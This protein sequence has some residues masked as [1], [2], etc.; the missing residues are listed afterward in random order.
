VDVAAASADLI[1]GCL[2][3]RV[4]EHVLHVLLLLLLMLTLRRRLILSTSVELAKADAAILLQVNAVPEVVKLMHQV[5]VASEGR[6]Q[7]AEQRVEWAVRIVCNSMSNGC[8]CSL[9]RLFI[10]SCEHEFL[11]AFRG[12]GLRF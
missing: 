7:G 2:C 1:R 4:R 12:I 6:E 5:F 3:V 8:V 10:R 11:F 9:E